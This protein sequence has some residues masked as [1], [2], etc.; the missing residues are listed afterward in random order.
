[1]NARRAGSNRG[2]AGS[3]SRASTT[4]SDSRFHECDSAALN[5]P[6][7]KRAGA[8]AEP[9]VASCC[10]RLPGVGAG[11]HAWSAVRNCAQTRRKCRILHWIAAVHPTTGSVDPTDALSW[12]CQTSNF[13][14]S[15]APESSVYALL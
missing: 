2:A 3:N 11:H 5:R 14:G 12:R 7:C 10:P 8:L 6:W 15:D 1:L 4:S 9:P 13:S